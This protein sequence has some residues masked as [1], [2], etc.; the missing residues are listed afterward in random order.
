[1]S[2]CDAFNENWFHPTDK[3]IIAKHNDL[4]YALGSFCGFD[5]TNLSQGALIGEKL[6]CPTCG[7]GYDVTTGF[8]ESG[9]NMRNLSTFPIS[10][11]NEI[12][13]LTV[14]EHVPAFSRKKF[15]KRETIDPR[16]FIILGDNETALSAIDALRTGFTG[17][18]IMIPQSN[19]GAFENTEIMKRDFTPLT[20][21]QTYLVETDYLDRANVDVI[22]GQVKMIDTINRKM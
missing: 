4:Y 16:T 6:M 7:S 19:F 5:Y 14:P 2:V 11:R 22:K 15:L 17:R 9:P 20:K 10:V 3:I 13:E 12:I 18:I 1:M 21:N 8:V